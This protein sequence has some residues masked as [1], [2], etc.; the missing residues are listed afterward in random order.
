MTT[1]SSFFS[2]ERQSTTLLSSSLSAT[3][4]FSFLCTN[5]LSVTTYRKDHSYF[6]H[7]HSYN[8]IIWKHND[9]S[10]LLTINLVLFT[11]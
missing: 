4:T 5:V 10:R 2:K 7:L 8:D 9:L 1:P 6:T 11:D 3:V